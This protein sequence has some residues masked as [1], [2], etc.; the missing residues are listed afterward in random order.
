[1]E[2]YCLAIMAVW[3]PKSP[4]IRFRKGTYKQIKLLFYHFSSLFWFFARL[5]VTLAKFAENTPARKNQNEEKYC[6]AIMAVWP[7][8]SPLIRFRKG[9]YKQI[10]MLFYH[11]SSLFWFFARLFVSLTLEK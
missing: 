5:F 7:P 4:L 10:K 9:T 6:F 8:K 3:P 11:F 2:N 1:M